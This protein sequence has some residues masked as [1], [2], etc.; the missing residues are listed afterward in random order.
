MYSYSG[1]ATATILWSKDAVNDIISQHNMYICRT[2]RW[3]ATKEC[4][5]GGTTPGAVLQLSSS[6][7]Y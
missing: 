6:V 2:Y 4:C 7:V 1:I 3:I 5:Y